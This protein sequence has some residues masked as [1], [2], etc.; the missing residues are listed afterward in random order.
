MMENV[1][2]LR[3]NLHELAKVQLGFY[4]T[5]CHRL[6]RLSK[7]L[8]V[9]IYLKREDVSGFTPFGGNKIRKLEYLLGDALEQGCDHVITFGAT[10]SNH[11][12]QTVAACRKYGLTPILFL[13]KV[14]TPDSQLRAN[15]LLDT[16]MGAELHI[17]DSREEAEAAA[18]VRE[19]NLEEAGHKCYV[20]PGG[21]ASAV[22]SIGFIDAF[23]E[24]SEQL[25]QNNIQPDYLF[26][27]TGSGGTLSG[28]LAGKKILGA[29]TKIVSVAVG[30][31]D[32]EYPAKILQLSSDTLER[33]RFDFSLTEDDLAIEHDFY[34]PGYE[35]PNEES[36]VAIRLLAETEGILLDPVYTGKAFSG[37]LHGIQS[38]KIPK[39][40]TV[41][42]LHT[43]G[44]LALFAEK[45]IVGD[46]LT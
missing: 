25:L 24:L 43:G 21:G 16:I 35:I 46:W 9:E 37:L 7:R 28:L 1:N 39:G 36:S 4:P 12:M 15:L 13:R 45:E 27:A 10:Q 40:S 42:F 5:P 19:Q 34:L 31:K 30:E 26:H 22:G 17:A 8:G 38:G 44:S 33:I 3:K 6:D 23:L 11:A 32:V 2:Q 18:K 14:I 20:I 29:S 41:V